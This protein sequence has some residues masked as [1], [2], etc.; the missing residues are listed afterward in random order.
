MWNVSCEAAA[1]KSML[2]TLL[3]LVIICYSFSQRSFEVITKFEWQ[4]IW[5]FRESNMEDMLIG[6]QS[7]GLLAKHN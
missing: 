2:N 1:A 4:N 6:E 7:G 5:A 3:D